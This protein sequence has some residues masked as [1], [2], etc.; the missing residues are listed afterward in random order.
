MSSAFYGAIT[1]TAPM[2]NEQYYIELSD[3]NICYYESRT[4]ENVNKITCSPKDIKIQVY[5]LP[6]K[7]EKVSLKLSSENIS[8]GYYDTDFVSLTDEYCEYDE[9]NQ[10]WAIFH[11]ESFLIEK[12][13]PSSSLP[14]SLPPS[15]F[16]FQYIAQN[17]VKATKSFSLYGGIEDAAKFNITANAIQ[18]C[19]S[20]NVLEFDEVGLKMYSG[21]D[22]VFGVD[23]DGNL[24]ITGV[25]DAKEGGNIGGF[26]ISSDQV[27]QS[28][29]RK[30]I[31]D[32]INEK[33]KVSDI[34]IGSE[35]FIEDQIGFSGY[36]RVQ[37][38]TPKKGTIYFTKEG[39]TYIES[40]ELTSFTEG[41][42]YYT[43]HTSYIYNPDK[44]DGKFIST[45]D[46][47]TILYNNGEMLLGSIKFDGNNSTISANYPKNSNLK[48]WELT[49][50]YASFNNVSV[51][52]SI[53]T[54]VFKTG[55]V[56]TAG[57]ALIFKESYKIEEITEDG[58]SYTLIVDGELGDYVS[59]DSDTQ[60]GWAII[61]NNYEL[62]KIESYQNNQVKVSK[63]PGSTSN[64]L[65]AKILVLI[66]QTSTMIMG[67]NATSVKV[68]N[69]HVLPRGL[70]L[71]T[72]NPDGSS[73][74][75]VN[76]FLGD[77]QNSGL[78]ELEGYGL[79]CDNVYLNGKMSATSNKDGTTY[80]AGID[81]KSNK[82]LEDR[83]N[84]PIVFWGEETTTEA[85]SSINF[86]V[87]QSGHLYGKGAHFEDGFFSGTIEAAEI[88]AAKIIGSGSNSN[89]PSLVI[90]STSGGISFG[91]TNEEEEEEYTEYYRFTSDGLLVKDKPIITISENEVNVNFDNIQTNASTGFLSLEAVLDEKGEK[92]IPALLHKQLDRNSHCGFYFEDTETAFKISKNNLQ[93]NKLQISDS[94]VQL[95]EEIVYN[96]GGNNGK[97]RF[98]PTDNGYNLYIETA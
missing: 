22:Q 78:S 28:S 86:A 44:H 3:E 35:A 41:Q 71:S 85:D 56:Q 60:Y 47:T 64:L 59:S 77:L 39:D 8:L 25:I 94:H 61:G 20:K 50:T 87:T 54:A 51:S 18:S 14:P 36:Q 88:K 31:L 67:M 5:E 52:G 4:N 80:S 53:D 73:A 89:P 37:E 49:P 82:T 26:T 75:T 95:C 15:T 42:E 66:G 79:Y 58:S 23:T 74:P 48:C 45:N 11:I 97:M 2:E 96:G 13:S 1:L 70:T 84:D 90:E 33:I 57:S 55:S 21:E 46:G 40:G 16:I 7:E 98:Q 10:G 19:V 43:K 72:F 32:G 9:E 83:P 24:S 81:T 63:Q 62:V 29:N 65:E 6:Y 76:L 92:T 17:K 34:E 68:A 69:E 93:V 91:H 38:I 30:L 12:F 27:L